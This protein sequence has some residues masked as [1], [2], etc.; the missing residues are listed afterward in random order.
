[1]VD[2]AASIL[3]IV[4]ENAIQTLYNLEVAGIQYFHIDVMDGEFVKNNTADK[5]KQYCEYLSSISSLP[6]DVHLMVEDVSQYIDNFL[7]F[8]PN[9]IT[10]HLEA[11]KKQEQVK[12]WIDKIKQ[13]HIKA[14]IAIKPN[15]KIEEVKEFLP[16][17]HCVLVMTVEPGEGGQ[18]LIPETIS[19][20]QELSEYRKQNHL[21]FD[22]EAD[23]GI[24]QE[25]ACLL[26]NAGT[27]I[28]VS[29]V[30]ILK[31]DN[32]AEIVKKLRQ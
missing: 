27:D 10:F 9:T 6:L 1:M 22:I 2:V 24:N 13:N 15:T 31:A 19:K 14:G 25:N 11:A 12:Q 5:M 4:P 20:I 8:E 17:L 3:S 26:K 32:F 29:G 21:E 16:Y 18:T 7:V 23:G 28:L 30:G